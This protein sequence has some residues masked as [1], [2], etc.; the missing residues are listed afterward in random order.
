MA[1]SESEAAADD[2]EISQAIVE[3]EI[4]LND[5][6]KHTGL[7]HMSNEKTT[8]IILCDDGSLK[9]YMADSLK[10]DYWLQPHQRQSNPSMQLK[11]N[12]I[13]SSTSLFQLTDASAYEFIRDN[14]LKFTIPQR[15]LATAAALT[16]AQAANSGSTTQANERHTIA[17]DFRPFRQGPVRRLICCHD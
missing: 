6:Y 9:I 5:I 10:T 17:S 13:W 16:N 4:Q 8:M 14:A 2:S 3:S 7:A 1:G 12:G 15:M 11:P